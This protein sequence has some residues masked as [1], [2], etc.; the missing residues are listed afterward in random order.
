MKRFVPWGIAGVALVIFTLTLRGQSQQAV[1]ATAKTPDEAAAPADAAT[2]GGESKEER[3]VHNFKDEAEL[4]AFTELWQHRQSIILRMT[5]LQAYWNQ[6]QAGLAE[7]NKMLASQ[8]QTDPTKNY[9]LDGDR[10][11]LIEQDSPPVPLPSSQPADA[12][13]P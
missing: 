7:L 4:R 5:V 13:T 11:V 9:F 10:R 6:E 3:I 2:P 1:T 12:P 8:Y